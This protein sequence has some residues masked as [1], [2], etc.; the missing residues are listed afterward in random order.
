MI[1]TVG[2]TLFVLSCLAWLI[3]LIIPFLGFSRG[4]TAGVITV[5]IIIGEVTFYLSI[6]LLGK[7]F[8][9]KIRE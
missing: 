8:Y 2:Y 7:T 5:L 6:L 3:I 9:N 4:Q 1:K